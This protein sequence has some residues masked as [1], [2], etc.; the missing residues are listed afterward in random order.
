MRQ[1]FIE[2]LN[3][4][5]NLRTTPYQPTAS[6]EAKLLTNVAPTTIRAALNLDKRKYKVQGSVG[7]GKWT[8]TPWIS[9][10]DKEITESAQQGFYIV[11]LF[12]KDMRGVYLSLNQ[13]TTYVASKFKGLNPKKKMKQIAENIRQSLDIDRTIF[14]NE[15]IDLKASTTNAKNYTAAHIC[16]KYYDALALPD[17]E[18]LKVD[19]KNLLKI[20]EQLKIQMAGRGTEEMLDYYLQKE[21]IEDTQ[22]QSDVQVAEPSNT[23]LVPQP[24]PPQV[25]SNGKQQWKRNASIAKEALRNEDYLCEVNNGHLSFTSA[26]TNKNFV[27]AHHLIPMK[28]QA[29]FSWSLDVPGNIVSLCPNCHRKIHHASKSERKELIEVL[30]SKKINRLKSFG[31]D[32]QLKDLLKAYA[33]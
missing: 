5:N 33:C 3:S 26:I 8:D 12:R 23:P 7:A 17:D 18:Q 24:V 19:L 4:Y 10:F 16:G 21:E 11:Y 28:L 27:E 2:I 20:Y 14:P 30:Y 29:L 1:Q 31:I 22:F 13:G 9:V 32:I 15:S 6:D 25:E